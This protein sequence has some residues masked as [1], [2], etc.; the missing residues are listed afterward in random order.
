VGQGP[1]RKVGKKKKRRKAERQG[2]K[3]LVLIGGGM[4]SRKEAQKTKESV[5]IS[6]GNQSKRGNFWDKRK[7]KWTTIHKQC[8]WKW[9][10][11]TKNW[12]HGRGVALLNKKKKKE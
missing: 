6:G 3:K 11:K 1:R 10:E 5:T 2:R 4:K 12:K 9:G 8:S 7:E